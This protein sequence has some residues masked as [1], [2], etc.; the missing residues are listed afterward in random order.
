MI[1][2]RQVRFES[3][4]SFNSFLGAFD[5][6]LLLETLTNL[7]AGKNVNVPIY[8]FKT[9]SRVPNKSR[10]VY[11][12]NIIVF[13]GIFALYDRRIR[14]LMDLRIFVDTDDDIRLARRCT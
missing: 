6:D 14:D 3:D 10:H 8:D 4:A 12:A 2:M 1:L 13:E 9:H 11:G 7:K 5:F